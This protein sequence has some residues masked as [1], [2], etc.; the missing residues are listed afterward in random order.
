MLAIM[1]AKIQQTIIQRTINLYKSVTV[2]F[3]DQLIIRSHTD[4][5]LPVFAPTRSIL[6][7]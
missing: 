2:K 3:T 5:V 7:M 1:K 4:S 6:N